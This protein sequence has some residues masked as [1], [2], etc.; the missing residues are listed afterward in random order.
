MTIGNL[1][2]VVGR[3]LFVAIRLWADLSLLAVSS[4]L[5][6][7]FLVRLSAQRLNIFLRY[8]LSLKQLLLLTFIT[9][10][11]DRPTVY[12]F[13]DHLIRWKLNIAFATLV[14]VLAHAGDHDLRS[15]PF[16]VDWSTGVLWLLVFFN[17]A[18]MRAFLTIH[19]FN[20]SNE[21][22]F[23]ILFQMGTCTFLVGLFAILMFLVL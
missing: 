14:H 15:Q 13:A 23:L 22:L 1:F 9:A 19:W 10:Y 4:Y 12:P 16:V 20:L 17:F 2:S 8:H 5:F 6:G 21:R 11:H 7:W 18:K 3:R